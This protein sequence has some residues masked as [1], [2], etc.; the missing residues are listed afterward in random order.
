[1]TIPAPRPDT[2]QAPPLEPAKQPQVPEEPGPD[3]T[4]PRIPLTEP[5]PPI[6]EPVIVGD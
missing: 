5:E 3:R 4:M 2:P 1:M 6:R